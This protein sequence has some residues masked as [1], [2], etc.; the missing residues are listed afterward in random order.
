MMTIHPTIARSNCR[1]T[2]D[3]EMMR[4]IPLLTMWYGKARRQ[5]TAQTC[6]FFTERSTSLMPARNC[7]STRGFAKACHLFEQA[8]AAIDDDKFPLFVAEGTSG[9]KKNKIRHNAY[10]YQC[11][12]VLTA[13]VREGR[14]CFFVFGHSLAENDDHVLKRL[15]KGR[16]PT[17]YVGIYGD[18][19]SESNRR[20][21]S[22]ANQIA[23]WR[24]PR[25]ALEVVFFDSASANVW[26][27][28]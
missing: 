4:T 26:G 2:M 15:G 6:C 17:L 18:P 24:G 13:N 8:R 5:L 1:R 14:H 3:S 23:S 20:I 16:F 27:A 11:Y 9:Q 7:R 10:L 12:K 21:I 22:R 19:H 28:E 25:N